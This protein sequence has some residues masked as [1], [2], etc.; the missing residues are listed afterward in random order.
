[1][2]CIQWLLHALLTIFKNLEKCD[3]L[4][5]AKKSSKHK[6][7]IVRCFS[8]T[9]R[10]VCYHMHLSSIKPAL[11]I[12]FFF[13]KVDFQVD[14]LIPLC[15]CNS[16]HKDRDGY[17]TCSGY[18][19]CPFSVACMLFFEVLPFTTLAVSVNGKTSKMTWQC[20]VCL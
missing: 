11:K 1:M 20:L 10:P 5:I 14:H 8:K 6:I 3:I 19:N 2:K 16:I 18:A 17:C 13:Q 12:L 9:A 4:K 15:T 7:S